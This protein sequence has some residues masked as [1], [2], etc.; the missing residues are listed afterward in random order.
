MTELV[1][2]LAACLHPLRKLAAGMIQ[3][4]G[5]AAASAANPLSTQVI[6]NKAGSDAVMAGG[7]LFIDASPVAEQGVTA[8][9][10]KASAG[11]IAKAGAIASPVEP[12]A[13]LRLQHQA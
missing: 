8:A 10:N 12:L 9:L 11:G 2:V 13:P 7:R 6:G 1:T 4:G 3:G 5:S